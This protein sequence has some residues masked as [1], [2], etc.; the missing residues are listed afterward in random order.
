MFFVN[1]GKRSDPFLVN[2]SAQSWYDA[3]TIEFRRRFSG[4]LLVQ[5][6][7]TFGKA[8]SNTY[9]SS[10]S[11][12]D[13]PATLRNLWLK[14]GVTPF[15][16][17]HG[18]KTNFIYEL[19]FGRGKTFLGGVNGLVDRLLVAGVSTATSA[20]KAAF[21]SVSTRRW[22]YK[23]VLPPSRITAISSWLE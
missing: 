17:R 9:A 11:V 16:I 6:S 3:V 13:Q 1:P 5:S 18:F 23:A 21:L 15:D 4:G 2:N 14:K 7:Y 10:S 8:L 12:F 22:D 20:S 19:P